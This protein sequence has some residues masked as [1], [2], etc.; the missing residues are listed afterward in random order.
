[1]KC[2]I[3]FKSL[4]V[5]F[6]IGVVLSIGLSA[7]MISINVYNYECVYFGACNDN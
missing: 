1:M 7:V 5:Q 2:K 6:A 4:Y 3:N